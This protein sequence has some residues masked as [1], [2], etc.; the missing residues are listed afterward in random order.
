MP[1]VRPLEREPAG[2][3]KRKRGLDTACQLLDAAAE[4]F[5]REGYDGVPM[6]AIAQRAGITESAIY[7]HFAGKQALLEAL[8]Q[9][10]I[11]KVPGTRPSEAELAAMMDMMQPREVFKAILFH[12]GKSVN[13]SLANTALIISHEKYRSARAAEMYRLYVVEEPVAYY[14]RLIGAMIR[15]G[16]VR[17]VDARL[18]AEQ[19]NYVCISLTKEYIMAQNGLGDVRAAVGA[20]VRAVGFFCDMMEN[21]AGQAGEPGRRGG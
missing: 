3:R 21:G 20:M 9:A 17:P 1:E 10:F 7:N 15:R 2:A 12:V 18:F 14:E 8:Y 19:Y 5:A 4:L 13:G 11:D 16:M 6:R